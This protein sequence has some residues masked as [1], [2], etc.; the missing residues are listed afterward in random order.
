MIGK[1]CFRFYI[2]VIL[3][4]LFNFCFCFSS[5]AANS[6]VISNI[7]ADK[8]GNLIVINGSGSQDFDLN[9]STLPDPDRFIIDINNAVLQGE[10][11]NIEV[12]NKSINDFRMS[13]FSVKPDVVRFVLAVDSKEMLKKIKVIRKKNTVFIYLDETENAVI[14]TNPLYADR[15]KPQKTEEKKE[16][17]KQEDIKNKTPKEKDDNSEVD[18]DSIIRALQEKIDH[19]IVLTK[20]SKEGNRVSISGQGILSV[21]E[22]ILLDEPKR[23]AFDILNGVVASKQF[24]EP[25]VLDNGDFLRIGQFNAN[26]VRVV[27]ESQQSENYKTIVSPDMQSILISPQSEVS[28]D[29][30]PD[31]SCIAKINQINVYKKDESTTKVLIISSNPIIHE[32]KHLKFPNE[33]HLDI[34]NVDKPDVEMI[35]NLPRTAQFHGVLFED[36][37]APVKGSKIKLPVNRTTKVQTRLSLDGRMLEITLEDVIPLISSLSTKRKIVL[38]AG[39]GGEDPGAMRNKI[40]EKCITLDVTE[41]VK[42]YLKQ[43][44]IQVVMTREKD[45][46]VSLKQRT[47]ITKSARPDAFVSIHVNSSESSRING[48]ETYWYTPGSFNLAK[49]VH[50]EMLNNISAHN[51]GTRNARFYVIRNANVPAILV[52]MGYLS[53]TEERRKLLTE[54][55]RDITAK[56][57][58]EGIFNYFKSLELKG[59][60]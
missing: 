13:Q 35:K 60:F 55:R 4:L 38:D 26:T 7:V 52:E 20:I 53:H 50:T 58:A 40:Q 15:E 18:K 28:I 25:I 43:Y 59:S 48:I 8:A 1:D 27:I 37:E 31:S 54:E 46:T 36:I 3:A 42:A 23:I 10:R 47:R 24:L 45:E 32:I 44:G 22:P 6:F 29:A 30:F 39:H 33:V 14:T 21:T 56:A 49:F 5:K 19:D 41:R 2:L 51:G 9:I 57:I 34:Y 17:E 11:R 12:D 16:E